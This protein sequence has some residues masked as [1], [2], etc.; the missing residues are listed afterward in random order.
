MIRGDEGPII[1]LPSQLITF[2]PYLQ[3]NRILL[4]SQS[5]FMDFVSVLLTLS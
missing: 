1:F 3:N 4:K 2:H 5:Y